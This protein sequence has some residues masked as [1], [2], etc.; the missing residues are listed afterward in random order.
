MLPSG[1][2]LLKI[3]LPKRL[4]NRLLKEASSNLNTSDSSSE[5]DSILEETNKA[6]SEGD[7]TM[8]VLPESTR[9]TTT[10]SI[11]SFGLENNSSLNE[12]DCIEDDPGEALEDLHQV[13]LYV[14]KNS[15]LKLVLL[16]LETSKEQFEL[17]S[18]I[19]IVIILNLNYSPLIVNCI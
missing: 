12:N 14:Q 16:S 18:T 15:R 10:V 1:C 9:F 2:Y 19:R 6:S 11:N 8:D 3:H 13:T 4:L 17:E 5:T 7:L